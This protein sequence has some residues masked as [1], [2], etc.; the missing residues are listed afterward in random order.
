MDGE[1]VKPRR[2]SEMRALLE[3]LLVG[4]PSAL[5]F[6]LDP[7]VIPP[8]GA[9]ALSLDL[10]VG[11]ALSAGTAPHPEGWGELMVMVGEG[12]HSSVQLSP[13]LKKEKT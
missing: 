11:H 9:A 2:E 5:A 1:L 8:L 7:A 6:H 13:S 12:A 10:E 3:D 4:K